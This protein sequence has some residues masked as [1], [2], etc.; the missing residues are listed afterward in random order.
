MILAVLHCIP[1]LPPARPF[2]RPID[3]FMDGTDQSNEDASVCTSG[4]LLAIKAIGG[5]FAGRYGE[6]TERGFADLADRLRLGADDTF[7]DC[8]SGRGLAAMQAAHDFGVRRSIGVELSAS[9]HSQAVA[10]LGRSAA[11]SSAAVNLIQGDC[12]EEGRW[13]AAGTLSTCTCAYA[14]NLL[15]GDELNGRLK[16]CVEGCSSIRRVAVLKPWPDGLD[17]YSEPY[18]VLCETTWAP[19]RTTLAWD[20]TSRTWT[21]EG[22]SIVYVYERADAL[23]SGNAALALAFVRAAAAWSTWSNCWSLSTTT[24]RR[25]LLYIPSLAILAHPRGAFAAEPKKKFTNRECLPPAAV[26]LQVAETTVGMEGQ[27]RQQSKD[28]LKHSD[29]ERAAAGL[30][31]WSR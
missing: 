4:E 22:G 1:R 11:A 10:R 16:R 6:I 29:E 27:L 21:Q 31:I 25:K 28:T 20:S 26:R 7:V 8:G 19:L 14:C 13:A 18:E 3:V 24:S 17:G 5:E 15:F 9:R 30:P 12:A 2:G 23:W